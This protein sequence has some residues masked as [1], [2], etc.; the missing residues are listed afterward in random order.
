MVKTHVSVFW[1]K[2]FLCC[3]ILILLL[4]CV[5]SSITQVSLTQAPITGDGGLLSSN[6]T[7]TAPCF[8]GIFPG[9]SN[10]ADVLR[11]L[12]AKAV[13]SSCTPFNYEGQGGVRGI[14]CSIGPV[15][16]YKQGVD[17]VA[18]IGIQ[19]SLIITVGEVIKV[20]GNPSAVLVTGT[21]TPPEEKQMSM[22]LYF[23]QIFTVLL[24]ND[25]KGSVFDIQPTSSI[26]N[27]VYDDP[28]SYKSARRYS[29]A[30]KGYGKYSQFFH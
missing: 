2:V 28:A 5:P 7:C 16:N 24:L 19:P 10:E 1:L 30:W 12:Q 22:M 6:N 3:T 9:I 25:Q 29:S 11:V 18:T 4:G 8:W 14:S 15:I 26:S 27:I 13:L 23:D 21:D 17:I 20:R